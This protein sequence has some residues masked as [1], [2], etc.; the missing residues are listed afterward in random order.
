MDIHPGSNA[1][2][3]SA[4][5]HGFQVTFYVL[6]AIAVAGALVAA[7]LAVSQPPLVEEVRAG[8]DEVVLEAA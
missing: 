5:T 1:L 6:A 2:G 8:A 3:A 4:L 7:L